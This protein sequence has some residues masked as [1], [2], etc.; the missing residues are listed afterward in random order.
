[1][2]W[3]YHLLGA[4]YYYTWFYLGS[5][6]KLMPIAK[7]EENQIENRKSY[8]YHKRNDI[9]I[10]WQYNNFIESLASA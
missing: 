4:S 10:L 8:K 9:N 3:K 7:K 5:K 1:M 2:M 6:S